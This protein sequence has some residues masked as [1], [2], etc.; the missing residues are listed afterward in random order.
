MAAIERAMPADRPAIEALLVSNDLPLDG[1]E[2]A[3][4]PAVVTRDGA[5]VMG[6]AAIVA[7][8]TAGLLRSVVVAE[9]VRGT[10]SVLAGPAAEAGFRRP[11]LRRPGSR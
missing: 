2:P 10:D 1:L 4:P 6:C 3:L 5:S 7:H 8:G 9:S 11:A